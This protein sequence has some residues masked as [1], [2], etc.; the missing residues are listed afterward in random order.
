MMRWA[1][2]A[3][4]WA[5]L[6]AMLALVVLPVSRLAIA[7]HTVE[8]AEGRVYLHRTFPGDALGLPRPVLTY[9]ETVQP[10]TERHNGGHSCRDEGG[11]MRYT[12]A[13]PVGSWSIYP[14]AGN[15]INDPAGYR[16]EACWRWHLGAVRFGATCLDATV[17]T[18]GGRP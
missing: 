10:L 5:G 1:W 17:F 2:T 16:W 8:I 13:G 15:C 14:W 6:I 4:A 11:P 7:P 12:R 3:A 9:I 18:N